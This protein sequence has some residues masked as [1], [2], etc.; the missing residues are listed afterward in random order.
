MD[1]LKDL[2]LWSK[3]KELVINRVINEDK[4]CF[5]A[6]KKGHIIQVSTGRFVFTMAICLIFLRL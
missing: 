5:N 6:Y 2:N 4:K 1:S 3:E